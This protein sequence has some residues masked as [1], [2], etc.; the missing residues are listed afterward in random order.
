MRDDFTK[1]IVPTECMSAL[2]ETVMRVMDLVCDYLDDL[3]MDNPQPPCRLKDYNKELIKENNVKIKKI[4]E[5]DIKLK[6][7]D[8]IWIL[9]LPNKGL[10]SSLFSSLLESEAIKSM[11]E[12]YVLANLLYEFTEKYIKEEDIKDLE[13]EVI[14]LFATT[15]IST[16]YQNLF[17][18]MYSTMELR[19]LLIRFRNALDKRAFYL[20]DD[21][22]VIFKDTSYEF[23]TTLVKLFTIAYDFIK[24]LQGHNFMFCEEKFNTLVYKVES[25]LEFPIDN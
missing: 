17:A 18:M 12:F 7:Q 2:D 13:R 15:V 19:D 6:K 21:D 4:N 20:S 10:F 23:V 16:L 3:L 11:E 14:T 1:D 5:W 25:L 8:N 24:K 9:Y 22:T